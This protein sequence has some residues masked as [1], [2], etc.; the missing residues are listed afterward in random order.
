MSYQL[1]L[2]IF[3]PPLTSTAVKITFFYEQNSPSY[4]TFNLKKKKIVTFGTKNGKMIVWYREAVKFDK[5]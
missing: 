5:T 2:E 3:V 1:Y 4:D